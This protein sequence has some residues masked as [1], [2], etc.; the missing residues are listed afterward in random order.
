MR[1]LV[2]AL[3][4]IQAS[5]RL[6]IKISVFGPKCYA[7]NSSFSGSIGYEKTTLCSSDGPS[8]ES[9]L[10]SFQPLMDSGRPE[11]LKPFLRF[12][13]LPICMESGREIELNPIITR[14]CSMCKRV[15]GKC[16]L[17]LKASGMIICGYIVISKCASAVMQ[18]VT[19]S[20]QVAELHVLSSMLWDWYNL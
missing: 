4:S 15:E 9:V 5:L 6:T 13:P 14:C 8:V 10:H 3:S 1:R 17:L 12:V 2:L 16:R 18:D 7:M 20:T 19:P 11:E